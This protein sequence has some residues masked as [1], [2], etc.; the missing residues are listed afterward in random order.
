MNGDI[1][2][3]VVFRGQP[4]RWFLTH[5]EISAQKVKNFVEAKY[6]M[7]NIAIDPSQKDEQHGITSMRTTKYGNAVHKIVIRIHQVTE[8]GRLVLIIY[9]LHI[10]KI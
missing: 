5:P 9:R 10:E 1:L 8:Y 4:L 6:I 7:R 2:P 3:H